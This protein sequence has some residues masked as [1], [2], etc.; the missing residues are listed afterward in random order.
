[1]VEAGE[2]EYSYSLKIR[3]LLKNKNAENAQASKIEPNWNVSGT[4]DFHPS[5]NKSAVGSEIRTPNPLSTICST[6]VAEILQ[7]WNV[8]SNPSTRSTAQGDPV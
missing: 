3:K 6:L 5:R 7:L 4:W 2:S 8:V 1:M